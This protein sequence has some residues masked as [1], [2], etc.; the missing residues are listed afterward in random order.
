[1]D[2]RLQS[3]PMKTLLVLSLLLQATS[4]RVYEKCELA[5]I[6][7]GSG[8]NDHYKSVGHWV[9][10]AETESGFNTGAKA[11]NLYGIF[12]IYGGDWCDD[13]TSQFSKNLCGI[14]C[15]NLLDNDI[16]DDIRCAIIVSQAHVGMEAWR[17]W[18]RNCGSRDVS[19]FLDD[20]SQ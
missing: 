7:Q 10:L 16:T 20:C 1:M 18:L 19:H 8:L 3:V 17:G 2:S 11:G 15:N 9:C 14:S 12:Q 13:G 5:R 4:G 6:F